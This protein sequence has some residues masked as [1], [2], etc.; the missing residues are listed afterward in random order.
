MAG[1]FSKLFGWLPLGPVA[2][3]SAEDMRTQLKKARREIQLVDVRT[4]EEFKRGHIKGSLNVPL[5]ILKKQ[6]A[7]LPFDKDRQIIAICYS[8]TRSIPALRILSDAGYK[9]AVQLQG[10]LRVWESKGYPVQKG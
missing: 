10:G 8:A 4:P 7:A 9:D 3:I 6:V 2:E 1:I 5:S